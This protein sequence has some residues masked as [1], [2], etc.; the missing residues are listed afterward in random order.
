MH[1]RDVVLLGGAD[2][3]WHPSIL[4]EASGH[5]SKP[6]SR[7]RSLVYIVWSSIGW[8]FLHQ[9]G[10]VEDPFTRR[11]GRAGYRIRSIP[12]QKGEGF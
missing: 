2:G 3:A 11:V 10:A 4:G 7:A 9:G 6:V 8:A 1:S 5:R 12:V